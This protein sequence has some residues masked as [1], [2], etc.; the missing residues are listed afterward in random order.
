MRVTGGAL[1]GRQVRVP[2]GEIRPAMDR[3]RES[4][5]SIIEPIG[6]RSFLDLFCGSGIMAIEA[7]SRGAWPVTL[8]EKDRGKRRVI[9]E[10]LAIANERPRLIIAPVEVFVKRERAPY[11]LL[12][13][14]PPFA[15]RHKADLLLRISGSRLIHD[16]ST[17]IIHYPSTEN[18]PNKMGLLEQSDERR[19]GG[20][21][22]AMFQT[23]TG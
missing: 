9:E 7:I 19:Y 3:M 20:S 21:V 22:L 17:V 16:A 18:L 23:L 4:L 14:D 5:F 2:P 6:G 15:Y 11:D 1:R 13:L 8:V 10:N 12:Y